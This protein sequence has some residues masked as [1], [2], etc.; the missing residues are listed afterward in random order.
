MKKKYIYLALVVIV[1]GVVY[2]A[3]QSYSRTVNFDDDDAPNHGNYKID[4]FVY[5]SKSTGTAPFDTTGGCSNGN[6]TTADDNC[7]RTNDTFMYNLEASISAATANATQSEGARMLV[8]IT[9]PDTTRV[10]L[11]V[12]GW[13]E[14]HINDPIVD[15]NGTTKTWLTYYEFDGLKPITGN[16]TISITFLALGYNATLNSSQLPTVKVWMAGT[17]SSYYG[18]WNSSSS[19]RDTI[20]ITGT[21]IL[22]YY[23]DGGG[24]YLTEP[25]DG[26]GDAFAQG[27]LSGIALRR[28]TGPDGSEYP[29]YRGVSY[30]TGPITY[31]LQLTTQR[32]IAGS[33][34]WTD[35]AN[36][37]VYISKSITH[38][39]YS[40]ATSG[41]GRFIPRNTFAFHSEHGYPYG[42]LYYNPNW[43]TDEYNQ[44]RKRR[45]YDSGNVTSN[46]SVSADGKTVTINYTI[47]DYKM[48]GIF[49]SQTSWGDPMKDPRAGYI[50]I[51]D[52]QVLAA[53]DYS[54][55][56]DYNTTYRLINQNHA[57]ANSGNNVYVS[58]YSSRTA[59]LFNF[60]THPRDVSNVLARQGYQSFLPAEFD[61]RL[62]SNGYA[63]YNEDRFISWDP[64]KVRLSCESG[65]TSSP[66]YRGCNIDNV[67]KNWDTWNDYGFTPEQGA[68]TVASLKNRAYIWYGV[69]KGNIANLATEE[70][71]NG[72]KYQTVLNQAYLDEYYWTGTVSDLDGRVVSAIR[73]IIPNNKIVSG[74]S[75]TNTLMLKGV[76]SVSQI[77]WNNRNNN[78][79]QI[80]Q[81]TRI[82]QTRTGCDLFAGYNPNN[83]NWI[84]VD[85]MNSRTYF[86]RTNY[87]NDGTIVN[88]ETDVAR[89]ETYIM[90]AA[91]VGVDIVAVNRANTG[92]KKN[93][94]IQED[95][96]LYLKL[97][98][99]LTLAP[100]MTN[101]S[102]VTITI[103]FPT[104]E[105]GLNSVDLNRFS[106]TMPCS[107]SDALTLTCSVTP[108]SNGTINPFYVTAPLNMLLN[109]GE[110]LEIK[111]IASHPQDITSEERRTSTWGIRI[112]NL[113]GSFGAKG[114]TSNTQSLTNGMITDTRYESEGYF[115]IKNLF[116]DTVGNITFDQYAQSGF[117]VD[118]G[119][120]NKGQ[121]ALTNLA[122]YEILPVSYPVEDRTHKVHG[123]YKIKL[124][125]P[126]GTTAYVAEIG[127]ASVSDD[128]FRDSGCGVFANKV[129]IGT[130]EYEIQVNKR[131]ALCI[132]FGSNV[133]S[134]NSTMKFGYTIKHSTPNQ[135]HH[136]DEFK[137]K[138]KY[139]S[140]LVTVVESNEVTAR[141]ERQ[142][143]KVLV[144]HLIEGTLDQVPGCMPSSIEMV[145]VGDYYQTSVCST[146]QGYTY[147]RLNPSY[148]AAS[149]TITKPIMSVV[150]L[151][152]PNNAIVRIHHCKEDA[153]NCSDSNPTG[154]LHADV[155]YTDYKWGDTYPEPKHSLPSFYL[156]SQLNDSGYEWNGVLPNN[157]QGVITSPDNPSPVDIYYYYRER[158]GDYV[159]HHYLKG[160]ESSATPT[161]LCPDEGENDLPYGRD[162]HTSK[163]TRLLDLFDEAVC[164]GASSVVPWNANGTINAPLTEITYCYSHKLANVVTN[165]YIQK[166][167]GTNTPYQADYN[168]TKTTD[169]VHASDYQIGLF[170]GDTYETFNYNPEDLDCDR[171]HDDTC[172]TTTSTGLNY[173]GRYEYYGVHDGDLTSSDVTN[174]PTTIHKSSYVINYYYTPRPTQLV[175]HHYKEGTTE[176]LC[177]SIYD[178]DAYYDKQ[179]HYEKCDNLNDSNYRYKRVFTNVHDGTI[180]TNNS[181]VSGFINQE[182]VEIIYEYERIPTSY[183]VHHYVADEYIPV[184]VDGPIKVFDDEITTEVRYGTLYDT[185]SKDSSILYQQYRNMYRYNGVVDGTPH[186]VISSDNMVITYYYEPIPVDVY[187]HHVDKRDTSKSVHADDVQHLYYGANYTTHYYETN[188]LI[189]EYKNT[190]SH[191]GVTYGDPVSGLIN[192]PKPNHQYHIYYE[193][194]MDQASY[195]VHHYICGT[196]TQ[197]SPDIRTT[198]NFGGAYHTNKIES[199]GLSGIYKD[200]YIYNTVTSTDPNA[201]VNTTTGETSGIF[202]QDRIEI[203]YCYVPKKANVIAHYKVCET[204]ETV[205]ADITQSNLD[206]GTDYYTT[207]LEASQLEGTYK[208]NYVYSRM[209]DDSDFASGRIEKTP[210]EV[211][212]CYVRDPIILTTRHYIKGTSIDV[213]S[214][215][216][217]ET[218]EELNRRDSYDKYK[219]TNL[220]AG[221]QYDSVRSDDTATILDQSGGRAHGTITKSTILTFEY[222]LQGIGLTVLY[223]DLDTGEKFDQYDKFL[224]KTY[225]DN[226]FERPININNYQYV[227]VEVDTGDD[228]N[229]E[230]SIT[231]N[232]GVVNGTI[233][234]N[235]TI[236]YYYRRVL[237]LVVHHYKN[238]TTT[239]VCEDEFNR[240]NY[241][242]AYEKD[243]CT[244]KLRLGQYK[245]IDVISTDNTTV[246]DKD[247]GKATGNIKNNITII[248]YYDIPEMV[249]QPTKT[250]TQ[251]I[252]TR[253]EVIDYNLVYVGDIRNYVGPVT[254][255]LTD[256]LPYPLNEG[257]SRIDLA[258]GTYD[259]STKT[260]TWTISEDINTGRNE[261]II[262]RIEKNI[263]VVY[264]DI[265]ATVT[266]INNTFNTTTELDGF[267]KETTTPFVTEFNL[268]KLT[269]IHRNERTNEEIPGC[270]MEVTENL[271]YGYEYSTIACQT[272]GSEY[273]LKSIKELDDVNL[274]PGSASGTITHDTVLIYY[275]DLTKYKLTVK[276]LDV[277]TN[278]ELVD[279]RVEDKYYGDPYD[280]GKITKDK[281]QFDHLYVSDNNATKTDDHVSGTITYD[282]EV[283]FFYKKYQTIHIIH[284]DIDTDEILYEETKDVPYRS[285]YEEHKKEFNKYEF[286]DVSSD[287]TET[288]IEEDKAS[289]IIEKDITLVYRYKKQLDLITHHYK[290]GTTE[291]ICAT[292]NEVLPYNTTYEKHKCDDEDLLD[293]YIYAYVESDNDESNINDPEGI[294]TGTIHDDTV[295]TYYYELTEITQ[296]LDK[297]GPELLHSRSKAFNYTITDNVSIKD[298]RGDATI[299]IVDKLDYPIDTANSIIGDGI[300]DP[301][302]LTITWIIAWNNINTN[303]E[304]NDTV[305]R[306]VSIAFTLYYRD[307]PQSVEVLTNRVEANVHTEKV[308]D[309]DD[310]YFDTTLDPFTLIVHHY[311]EGTT[312]EL[313][314]TTTELLDED[315]V[316]TK[317]ICDLDEYDYIEVK[318]NGTK[319]PNNPETVSEAITGDTTLDFIYRKKDSTLET[320]LTKKGP[321]ELTSIYQE[322]T[323]EIHYEG[324]VIDY[325]G[326][327]VVTITDTLPY[328]IDT[329]RSSLDGGE[330]DGEYKI[331]WKVNWNDID[332]YNGKNDTIKV[333]KQIT[334]VFLDVNIDRKI[335]TNEA[336]AKTV[337]SDKTDLVSATKDTDIKLPGQI[338]VH[339]YIVDTTDRLFDDDEETGLV[340]E[341]YHA[342]PHEK[343][344][345]YVVT[346]PPREDVEFTLEPQVL[347]YE[348]DKYR[349]NIVT[350]VIGGS[351]TITG[352]EEVSYD[353]DSTEDNIVITP[354][355]GYEIERVI[356]DGVEIEITNKDK[357]I[358]T[359]FKKVRENHLVQV[360]FSE[361]PIEVPITGVKTKLIILA[362]ILVIINIVFF[363][364]SGFA[365]KLFKKKKRLEE[366]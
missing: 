138:F 65:S 259:P 69:Y 346:R 190:Y 21:P 185:S 245:Y 216:C 267:I 247:T 124:N 282:T 34:T 206:F 359:N 354:D 228:T 250:G 202:N 152:S 165:H 330:Y 210:I 145:Y 45:V 284:K 345:Y 125:L 321:D 104:N 118:S 188:D 214:T 293:K 106:A 95:S 201:T 251:H 64:S 193:Y 336:E 350:E 194:D 127:N 222:S 332:T 184:G 101:G 103:K 173:R 200:N 261:S 262:K 341:K 298:Y 111:A 224:N 170:W 72:T 220:P 290:K 98:P 84:Y 36:N 232:T 2:F 304:P 102:P 99:Y 189:G 155:V 115:L 291:S 269:V 42:K 318:K 147:T 174:P 146:A 212:Y 61:V 191:T 141:I 88:L 312:Q 230:Y 71:I 22:D 236:R 112:V 135:A 248:Y 297:T 186:G 243:P 270:P 30:P 264:K 211:T 37:I 28:K 143:A 366:F 180:T 278:E 285:E 142:P 266:K 172:T 150:Y 260:I 90:T 133:L 75:W 164:D 305:T 47:T 258:G 27:I 329:N 234:K 240:L 277:D 122:A 347:I 315:T 119:F 197:V 217:P 128:S 23:V 176:S 80:L 343:E 296:D 11:A 273:T 85:V 5:N 342:E 35:L 123:N 221:Y 231:P 340:H 204:G 242:V 68:E 66:N 24:S 213:S 283:T 324:H 205:H 63:H 263:K 43:T 225:G 136:E 53:I 156:P 79:I 255:T 38:M 292:E 226:V 41:D 171:T 335:M 311:K 78:R 357:M 58:A 239:S 314:P 352:D 151:Y 157:Y 31:S 44:A 139:K 120:G 166:H 209:S 154:Q 153:T 8:E 9:I 307:V 60:F 365:K 83:D 15:S 274:I 86:T 117:Y 252:D 4:R 306:N 67:F 17:G 29:D 129:S 289:G 100:G 7:V 241:N 249:P 113:S 356:V 10:N 316:Y 355:D 169:K 363:A 182:Y 207:R 18:I 57:D 12:D 333:D 181:T 302:N 351:G 54:L 52:T 338:T 177:D 40:S 82:C 59:G 108:N 77:D 1:L 116:D 301:N 327:G 303:G 358:V 215:T 148:D 276:H 137:F 323:Y 159:A 50:S 348:Y 279:T 246:L 344:G 16:Q 114:I 162:Y 227:T 6:D 272:L 328:R 149:G 337:L 74:T 322:V 160:T 286:V 310:D 300:Y 281:Y 364:Q 218:N 81:K 97:S 196:T 167:D 257:D 121:N 179:I 110:E 76:F 107:K 235:T 331:V 70:V 49:P 144:N 158:K 237:D 56:A 313:C 168:G 178:Q 134:P 268:Y 317:S 275:Y 25:E 96:L 89:G 265:P 62:T 140:N 288:N 51:V 132:D 271:N 73:I 256:K 26:Y 362:I 161:L 183:T 163:C 126:S 353:D 109:N 223:Y 254:Y 46:Y 131:Y 299:T 325:R 309:D 94:N 3:S 198:E 208:D 187:T 219:C 320:V 326:D 48:D 195:I 19:G 238:G 14:G 361:K 105:N 92:T 87:A 93:Y 175:V 55:N 339:H 360:V 294:V 349:F 244:D 20:T 39:D 287:D 199:S 253:D 308:D 229:S 13:M 319:I 334:V 32:A 130:S 192:S 91:Q 233:R 295:I 203:T 33:G 280:E